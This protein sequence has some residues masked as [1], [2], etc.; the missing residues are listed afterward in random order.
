[1]EEIVKILVRR[2]GITKGEAWNLVEECKRE[3]RYCDS[4]DEAENI[5]MD[6]LGLEP[7]YLELLLE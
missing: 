1:M 5:V 4:I 6:Y 7:D 3:L 2:D